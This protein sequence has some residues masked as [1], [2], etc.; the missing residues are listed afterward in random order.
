[1]KAAMIFFQLA[2]HQNQIFIIY[3]HG[4]ILFADNR[5]VPETSGAELLFKYYNNISL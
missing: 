5:S 2:V 3:I 4:F 1:M